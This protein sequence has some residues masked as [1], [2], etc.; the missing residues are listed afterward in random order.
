MKTTSPIS[1][2]LDVWQEWPFFMEN[3]WMVSCLAS[4]SPLGSFS[5]L[6][7][8]RFELFPLFRIFH[9]TLLQD[10]AG[11]TDLPERHGVCGKNSG[12]QKYSL[13]ER[14]ANTGALVKPEEYG[15][16][17]PMSCLRRTVNITTLSNGFWRTTPLSWTSGFASMRTTL[18]RCSSPLPRNPDCRQRVLALAACWTL[19]H[20][21]LPFQTYQVD[22]KPSG[23]DMVVT[24]ENKN[25]YIE[26][27]HSHVFNFFGHFIEKMR[28][29]FCFTICPF[30]WQPGHPVE[31][32]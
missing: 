15:A 16:D 13:T 17:L 22:L 30:L 4:R 23:S 3:Y 32:C 2:S 6:S 9:S 27:D 11:K 25:E 8:T 1:S 21:N 29:R 5:S 18:G 28:E 26:W 20:R 24:N 12:M 14:C 31:V 10:D 19:P 7:C